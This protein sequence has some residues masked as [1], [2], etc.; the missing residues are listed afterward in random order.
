MEIN[1]QAP[2][3]LVGTDTGQT[4]AS[5]ASFHLN[6]EL[7]VT[8]AHTMTGFQ[9]SFLGIGKL[10]DEDCTVLFTKQS[11]QVCNPDG[12]T[13]LTGQH[14]PSGPRL[15]NLSLLPQSTDTPSTAPGTTTTNDAAFSDYGIPSVEDLVRFYHAYQAYLSSTPGYAPSSLENILLDL[16]SRLPM[17]QITALITL[18]PIGST[19]PGHVK[20]FVPPSKKVELSH[21]RH[22][23]RN[24][25]HLSLPT[26]SKSVLIPSENYTPT[27]WV[28]SS[29]VIGVATSTS[30]WPTTA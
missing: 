17:P 3:T 23:Y 15:W 29:S 20:G 11:V 19:R 16:A 28:V 10:C 14:D 4:Q 2:K 24:P 13:I 21:L 9:H 26:K 6:L 12:A 18:R 30:C 8:D 22:L 27:T 5:S 25:F 1:Q 7:P